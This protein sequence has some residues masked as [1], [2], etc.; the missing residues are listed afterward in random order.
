[1]KGPEVIRRYLFW[2]LRVDSEFELPEWEPYLV[3]KAEGGVDVRFVR[4]E[5]PGCARD[6]E[7]VTFECRDDEAL[8]GFP[9][10]GW[11]RVTPSR[12]EVS[13]APDA[14]ARE[15]RLFLLGSAWGALCYRRRLVPLHASAVVAGQR[16]IAFAGPSGSGKSTLA[17]SLSLHGHRV[18]TDDLCRVEVDP[19]G[20]PVVWPGAPWV[21]LWKEALDALG[22]SHDGLERDHFRM[23]KFHLSTESPP[24]PDPVP[25]HAI[26][27]LEWGEELLERLDGR[28]ALRQLVAGATYRPEL[29]G[30]EALMGGHWSRCLDLVRRVPIFRLRRPRDLSSGE[31]WATR[32]LE[33]T[34]SSAPSWPPSRKIL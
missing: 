32:I 33:A 5:P 9:A 20:R 16:A 34:P 24:G 29:L 17:W 1:M 6:P 30:N 2:G 31:R 27:L 13:P 22:V 23:E 14:G 18:L 10:A 7:A 4:G 11:F 19:G 26:Y 3:P 15:L 8:L 25:L 12:I 21:K 28:E